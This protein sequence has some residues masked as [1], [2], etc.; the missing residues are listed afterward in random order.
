MTMRTDHAIAVYFIA[1]G[2]AAQKRLLRYAPDELRRYEYT[3]KAKRIN[4]EASEEDTEKCIG[5]IVHILL[6]SGRTKA[7]VSDMTSGDVVIV[8]GS[9]FTR[10]KD[11]DTL[12]V[13]KDAMYIQAIAGSEKHLVFNAYSAL[14]SLRK[15]E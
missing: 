4:L 14:Q 11:A 3:S 2:K 9:K 6:T 5:Q 8:N 13:Y 10:Y 15:D 1:G 12:K 7:I